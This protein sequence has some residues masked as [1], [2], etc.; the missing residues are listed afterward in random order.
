MTRALEMDFTK[1][2][3]TEQVQEHKQW[4]TLQNSRALTQSSQN[5]EALKTRST[6]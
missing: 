5:R 3:S 1:Y 2:K 6:A 4:S